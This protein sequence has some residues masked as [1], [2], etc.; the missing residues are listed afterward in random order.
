MTNQWVIPLIVDIDLLNV[1]P[2]K[3]LQQLAEVSPKIIINDVNKWIANNISSSDKMMQ[4]LANKLKEGYK[5]VNA[6]DEFLGSVD[7]AIVASELKTLTYADISATQSVDNLRKWKAWIELVLE[8][9]YSTDIVHNVDEDRFNMYIG[10]LSDIAGEYEGDAAAQ[11]AI[12]VLM[13]NME[14][15]KSLFKAP[16]FKKQVSTVLRGVLYKKEML[17]TIL[18]GINFLLPKIE[19]GEDPIVWRYL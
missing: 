9:P 18:Y 17:A 4:M 19:A 12:S 2:M 13:R 16:P 14:K 11:N 3:A 8:S 5:E 6:R 10:R 1:I 15:K 7:T